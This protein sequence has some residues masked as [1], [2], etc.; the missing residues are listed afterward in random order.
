MKKKR[1]RGDLEA[2]AG[3]SPSFLFR[4]ETSTGV[5]PSKSRDLAHS[6]TNKEEGE[7]GK[8]EKTGGLVPGNAARVRMTSVA[9][10]KRV[11]RKG[12]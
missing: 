9:R 2:R 10:D 1:E 12:R 6:E 4:A 5:G 11:D 8:G 7:E 3:G